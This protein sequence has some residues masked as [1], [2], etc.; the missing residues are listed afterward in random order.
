[1]SRSK[2]VALGASIGLI[3]TACSPGSGG[4]DPTTNTGSETSESTDQATVTVRIWDETIAPAYE[5]SF[6]AFEDKHPNIKVELEL[7]SWDQYWERLPR[8]ISSGDMADI[9]WVNSSNFGL[10]VD[11]GNLLSITDELGDDHDEWVESI[12]NLYTRDDKLWGV[13]QIWDSIGL[14]YN[15]S[16]VDEAGVDVNSLKWVPGAGDGD[17]LLAAAQKLTKDSDGNTADSDGFNANSISTY[18]FNSQ[19]DLQA[20]YIDFLAQNGAE[21]QGDD[22]MFNFDTPEGIEAFQYLVDLVNEYHVAPPASETNL[23]GN[24]SRDLFVRGELGLFQSG[25]YSLNHIVDNADFEW[26]IAP[27]VEGPEGRISVVHGVS[28]VGNAATDNKDATVEVLKWM[29]SA[30]GQA[31][32]AELGVSFPGAVDAQGAYVDYWAAKGVDVSVFINAAEEPT[33]PA[34]RGPQVGA[35]SGVISPIIKDIFLGSVSVED[36][37]KR[38]Q[39]EGNAAMAE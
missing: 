33:A 17:T 10:Y 31:P 18:G 12:V 23:D 27:L 22:D 35:G 37:L 21:F 8:D 28:A 24:Y 30:E 36:G 7:V 3:L 9:F 38:A 1:M 11:N 29:G 34:P 25:P 6:A 5:E 20:I 19:D 13:P 2:V 32:I 14:F 15:K 39:E 26:G 4:S 16:L